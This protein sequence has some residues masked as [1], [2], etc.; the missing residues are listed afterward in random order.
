MT[1]RAG[2]LKYQI[3]IQAPVDTPD[4]SGGQSRAW[5]PV[6]TR[7]AGQ[8][9]KGSRVFHVMQQRYTQISH[10]FRLRD[11]EVLPEFRIVF[12][13]EPH[14][15]VGIETQGRETLLMTEIEQRTKTYGH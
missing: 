2:R 14:R 5:T 10:I 4:G 9:I 13:D 11:V 3:H 7:R 1:A 6:I 8:E 15:I 12:E